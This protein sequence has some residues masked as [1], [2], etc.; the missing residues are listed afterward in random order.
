MPG[1]EARRAEALDEDLRAFLP[2]WPENHCFLAVF[3]S[4]SASSQACESG[5]SGK[6]GLSGNLKSVSYRG[7]KGP[8]L[9]ASPRPIPGKTPKATSSGRPTKKKLLKWPEMP[10]WP[11][12]EMTVLPVLAE[13][14]V[15]EPL[16]VLRTTTT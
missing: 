6:T 12:P 11:V 15:P 8:K 2:K 9:E 4:M 10:L 5:L 3:W 1:T 16:V 7:P 14:P 13:R